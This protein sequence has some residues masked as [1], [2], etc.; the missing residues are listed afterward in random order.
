MS[1][2]GRGSPKEYSCITVSKSIYWLSE[3]LLKD[4]L[5]LALGAILFNGVEW[6]EQF[7]LRV[8]QGIFLYNYFKIHLL[9][10]SEKSFKD[11]LF[12]AP[13]AILFNGAEHFEQFR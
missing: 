9:V 2:F 4:F 11:F 5:F 8:T 12:L 6:F 3:K 1:N 10:K 13:A 7:W